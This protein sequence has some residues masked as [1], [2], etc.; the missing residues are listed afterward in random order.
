MEHFSAVAL[1][2]ALVL[3]PWYWLALAALVGF[4]V[5]DLCA[6]AI[7]LRSKRWIDRTPMDRD[8][9]ERWLRFDRVVGADG[10][11]AMIIVLMVRFG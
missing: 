7:D 9:C 1:G 5:I 4:V 8:Y 6:G 10:L 2:L 11:S 3:S